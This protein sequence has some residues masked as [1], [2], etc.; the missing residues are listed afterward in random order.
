MILDKEPRNQ[1]MHSRVGDAC[2]NTGEY[3]KALEHYKASL[4]IR[5]DPYA[6]LGMAKIHL[7]RENYSEAEKCCQQVLDNTPNYPRAL[8][9]MAEIYRAAG[10]EEKEKEMLAR[11]ANQ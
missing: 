10:E 9:E 8:E 4:S 7:V 1:V 11:L 3:D 5:F 2:L 6:C